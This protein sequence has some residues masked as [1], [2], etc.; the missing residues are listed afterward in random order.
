MVVLR[1]NRSKISVSPRIDYERVCSKN[2][3]IVVELNEL[4]SRERITRRTKGS[5]TGYIVPKV[6]VE[7]NPAVGDIVVG[8][9]IVS[10]SAFTND[11]MDDV[12]VNSDASV[13][14]I[15]V[16]VVRWERGM[17]LVPDCIVVKRPARLKGGSRRIVNRIV[18]T[19][20]HVHDRT[21]R[22]LTTS[23]LRKFAIINRHLTAKN[24]NAA[25]IGY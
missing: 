8:D 23:R 1:Y 25:A 17:V 3:S 2:D 20:S 22:H 18:G 10:D 24:C 21:P 19:V 5:L 11:V 7:F 6:V 4:A 14:R 12:V 16:S 15:N 9:I 13:I